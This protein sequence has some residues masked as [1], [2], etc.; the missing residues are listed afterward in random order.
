MTI[1]LTLQNFSRILEKLIK[2]YYLSTNLIKFCD[3]YIVIIRLKSLIK[4][5]SE[6]SI[7]WVVAGII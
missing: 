2:K 5:K 7:N 1:F 3:V 6:Q 4:L